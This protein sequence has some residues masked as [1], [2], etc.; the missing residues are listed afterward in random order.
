MYA[1]M[2]SEQ[3]ITPQYLVDQVQKVEHNALAGGQRRVAPGGEGVGGG[4]DGGLELVLR[5]KGHLGDEFLRGR[6]VYGEMLGGLGLDELAC[7]F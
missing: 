5:A 7:V 4:F 3:P 6:V 2:H 1:Y